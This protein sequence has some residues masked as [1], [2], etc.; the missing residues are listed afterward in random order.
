MVILA[1]DIGGTKTHLGLWRLDPEHHTARPIRFE[2]RVSADFED[3]AALVRSAFPELAAGAHGALGESGEIGPVE[4]AAFG[5][6]A[7][8]FAG[9]AETPN[10]AWPTLIEEEIANALG[11][12]RVVLLN[13]LAAAA[14]AI[15]LLP[16]DRFEVLQEG[17][18]STGP[19]LLVSAGTGLG[20]ALLVMDDLGRTIVVPCEGGHADFAPRDALGFE[21]LEFLAA[22]Y[23]TVSQGHVGVE[24]VVSGRGIA[25][26]YDFLIEKRAAEPTEEVTRAA[27]R[28]DDLA[29]A[30]SAAAESS[31]TAAQTLDLMIDAYGAA[32]GNFALIT[33]ATGGVFLGGGVAPRLRARMKGGGFLRA[34]RAKGRFERYLERIPVRLILDDRLGL[35][36]AAATAAS[37]VLGRP[38]SFAEFRV[39]TPYGGKLST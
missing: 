17:D 13:D 22:R 16:A 18:S 6:P 7:P 14:A 30:I 25:D 33:G 26:L 12:N 9:R 24:R 27:E 4:V 36:G 39:D 5:V 37:L 20:V 32:A 1:G 38:P 3:L 21:L 8:V 29:A 35:F 11:L 28:G 15:D 10:L 2:S 31:A 19:R 34:F 23:A